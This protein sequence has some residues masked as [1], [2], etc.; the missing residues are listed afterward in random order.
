MRSVSQGSL[1]K[2][3]NLVL[4]QLNGTKNNIVF[5]RKNM[6]TPKDIST[7]KNKV[8]IKKYVNNIISK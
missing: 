5:G 4:E 1:L 8:Q 3:Y 7:Q 2:L 6:P